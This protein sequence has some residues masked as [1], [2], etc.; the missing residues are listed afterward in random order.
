MSYFNILAQ[1]MSSMFVRGI[2]EIAELLVAIKRIQQFLLNE[3]FVEIKQ[4]TNNNEMLKNNRTMLAL[5]NVTA[6]W[7]PAS[8]DNVLNDMDISMPKGTFL[9]V[10]GPVGSSKSSLLQAILGKNSSFCRLFIR[11]IIMA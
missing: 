9:G 3:E 6:K 8:S 5:R 1:T 2:S 10:I 11:S 4:S 7:N